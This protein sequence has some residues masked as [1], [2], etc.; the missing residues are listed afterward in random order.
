MSQVSYTA[1]TALLAALVIGHPAPSSSQNIRRRTVNLDSYKLGVGANYSS[2]VVLTD[3]T[4]QLR[5]FTAPTYV[6]TASLLVKKIAPA[7]EYRLVSS[8]QSDNGVGHVVFKQTLHGIDIDT[9]D[10]NVNVSCAIA[11][12]ALLIDS[13][14]QRWQSFLLWKFFFYWSSSFRKP[15]DQARSGQSGSSFNGSIQHPPTLR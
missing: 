1:V 13:G 3:E 4:P 2:N 6:E 7:A 14:W 15:L 9:A 11:I 10:F 8:Y 12:S 5:T